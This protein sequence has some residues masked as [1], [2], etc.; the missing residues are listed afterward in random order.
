M[1]I[2]DVVVRWPGSYHDSFIF[3]ASH[4]CV[5][6][7]NDNNELILLGDNGWYQKI[8]NTYLLLYSN[9]YHHTCIN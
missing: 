7:S 2:F 9:L 8:F 4:A 6:F 3:N 5:V 1:E